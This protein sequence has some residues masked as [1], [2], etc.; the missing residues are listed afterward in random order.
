MQI[1]AKTQECLRFARAAKELWKLD[2]MIML[3]LLPRPVA[4]KL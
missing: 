1:E 3:G 2:R 4:H